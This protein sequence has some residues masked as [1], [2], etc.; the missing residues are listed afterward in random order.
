MLSRALALWVVC[1][2]VMLFEAGNRSGGVGGAAVRAGCDVDVV[3]GVGVGL[4]NYAMSC[5]V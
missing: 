3:K 1:G 2:A 4:K 5:T